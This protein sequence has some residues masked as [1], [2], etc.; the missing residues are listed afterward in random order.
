[1]LYYSEVGD[2]SGGGGGDGCVRSS[3]GNASIGMVG[4]GSYTS[5]LP[6][7]ETLAGSR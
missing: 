6:S 7:D 2:C 3:Y 1:M 5:G 4:D